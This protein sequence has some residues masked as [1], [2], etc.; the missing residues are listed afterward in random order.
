MKKE[1]MVLL[2]IGLILFSPVVSAFSFND[3]I[4]SIS[5]FFKN[6]FGQKVGEDLSLKSDIGGKEELSNKE[7]PSKDAF[8]AENPNGEGIPNPEEQSHLACASN[9]CISV[10][11]EGE[12]ECESNEDCVEDTPIIDAQ[13]ANVGLECT[14]GEI[15]SRECGDY[16]TGVCQ[17]G[18]QSQTCGDNGKWPLFW[19]KCEGNT[20]PQEKDEDGDPE[21]QTCDDGLDNDCDK[22]T[23]LADC[24]DM[25]CYDANNC[26]ENICDN[27]ID[28]DSDGIVD[29]LDLSCNDCKSSKK[30]SLTELEVP[31]EVIYTNQKLENALCKYNPLENEDTA[32]VSNC[33]RLKVMETECTSKGVDA[34]NNA[35][36]FSDCGIGEEI[37]EQQVTCYI[38]EEK[39]A[40]IE[41]PITSLIT[42]SEFTTCNLDGE[43]IGEVNAELV[44]NFE[45]NYPSENDEFEISQELDV[46][47]GF[48]NQDQENNE[49]TLE[50]QI[51][52]KDNYYEVAYALTDEEVEYLETAT[53][54]IENLTIPDVE[55]GE[56]AF[57]VKIYKTNNENELC[58]SKGISINIIQPLETELPPPEEEIVDQQIEDDTLFQTIETEEQTSGGGGQLG[59][60]YNENVRDTLNDGESTLTIIIVVLIVLIISAGTMLFVFR[61]KIFGKSSKQS[62][63]NYE[64][65]EKNQNMIKN[66]IQEAKTKGMNPH[67]IKEALIK[68]G[69]REDDI[70]RLL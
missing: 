37:G 13:Q 8:P 56:Y 57:Y 26:N 47:V 11:G 65:N 63:T 50:A 45:I 6:L 19:K 30:L 29:C 10:L 32:S 42:V 69:W 22:S 58:T 14:S 40:F 44:Q 18:T 61:K 46:E 20:D 43:T 35:V 51:L 59:L 24:D 7:I 1:V 31:E 5:D 34:V 62:V 67:E 55:E 2:V 49:F 33:I 27:A 68:S 66:Y 28:D 54:L 12:D 17:Y 4:T 64:M 53:I 23:S 3:V 60:D 15:R 16:N 21:E 52:S 70:N 38:D 48:S 9:S 41:S 36:I 39:C 25:D